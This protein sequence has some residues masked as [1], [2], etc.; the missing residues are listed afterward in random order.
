MILNCIAIDDEPLALGLIVSFIE[1]TP[2]LKLTGA[3]ASAIEALE[4]IDQLDVQLIFLDI[5]M[6]ELTGME[7]S[8]IINRPGLI[9][10]LF[11][12]LHLIN[13]LLKDIR[14][15]LYSIY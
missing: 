1:K 15:T 3:Y 10:K 11:L 5:H 13:L 9:V 8:K 6:P 4:R 12:L 14:W 7:F 2:F